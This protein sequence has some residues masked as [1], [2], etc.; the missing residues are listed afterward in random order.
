MNASL[1]CY[2]AAGVVGTLLFRR[3]GFGTGVPP[4]VI[5]EV[6]VFSLVDDFFDFAGGTS[7]CIAGGWDGAREGTGVLPLIGVPCRLVVA[8]CK[9]GTKRASFFLEDSLKLPGSPTRGASS[10]YSPRYRV[11]NAIASIRV[12]VS[13][14]AE[15]CWPGAAF[16][17]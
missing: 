3:F 15:V 1:I 6:G 14:A 8:A 4:G 17:V 13:A 5:P 12:R 9:L 2:N 10:I 11:D 16:P 7:V